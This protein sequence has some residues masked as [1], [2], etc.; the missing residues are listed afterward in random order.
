MALIALVATL[1]GIIVQII[2][3]SRALYGLAQRANLPAALGKASRRTRTPVVATAAT[4]AVVLGL[5]P[6]APLNDL[7]EAMSRL[8]LLVFALVNTS[9]IRIKKSAQLPPG[10]YQAPSWIPWAEPAH[11]LAVGRG[12]GGE[13]LGLICTRRECA[14]RV[15]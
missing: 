9:L 6:M 4:T 7:A 5:A 15:D 8:M 2:M 11:A 12:C 13:A 14:V 1:N 3:S 10:L